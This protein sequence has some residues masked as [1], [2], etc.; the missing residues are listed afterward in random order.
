MYFSAFC[1][2]LKSQCLL[3]VRDKVSHIRNS[4]KIIVLRTIH[5]VFIRQTGKHACLDLRWQAFP[6][7]NLS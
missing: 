4:S 5:Y 6:Q 2:Q 1:F 3:I 7:L